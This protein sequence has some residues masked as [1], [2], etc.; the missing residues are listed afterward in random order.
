MGAAIKLGAGSYGEV[1]SCGLHAVKTTDMFRCNGNILEAAIAAELR[2]DPRPHLVG[3][4]SVDVDQFGTISTSME[5]GKSSLSVYLRRQDSPTRQYLQKHAGNLITQIAQGLLSLH[6]RGFVHGDVKPAN[7]ICVD[8]DTSLRLKLIDFGCSRSHL[9]Q[10]GSEVERGR[11]PGT[12]QCSAQNHSFQAQS[13][14]PHG[15]FGD[16][17]AFYT[18]CCL[19]RF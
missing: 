7:I 18:A 10:T 16:S 6:A 12:S 14:P 15:M 13:Q 19:D 4:E 3:V 1:H 11:G 9:P 2:D 17:V 8:T 5:R